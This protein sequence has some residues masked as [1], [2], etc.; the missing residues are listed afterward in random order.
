MKQ[1]D[2][3][4]LEAKQREEEEKAQ[5]EAEALRLQKEEEASLLYIGQQL[6]GNTQCCTFNWGAK[7]NLSLLNGVFSSF[8]SDIS[9]RLSLLLLCRRA[10]DESFDNS[11][12]AL[13]I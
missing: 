4:A 3:A 7:N 12:L 1:D 6:L 9:Q 5:K 11:L 13:P 8:K 2:T 10:I